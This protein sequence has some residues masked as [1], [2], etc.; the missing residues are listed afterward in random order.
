MS[1]EKLRGWLRDAV[2]GGVLG[3]IIGA[4]IA[5][6]VVIFSGIEQGYEAT[7]GE[8]FDRSI[9]LGFVVV[10]ILIS[11]PLIGIAALRK[12]RTL[13]RRSDGP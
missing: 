8:V 1:D 7:L 11:G 9:W 12:R 10:T 3:G 4:I 6:N 5:V 2:M 13:N